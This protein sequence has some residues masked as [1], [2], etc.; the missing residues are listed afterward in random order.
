VGRIGGSDRIQTAF[1]VSQLEFPTG[2]APAATAVVLA[3]SDPN[4]FADALVGQPLAVAKGAPILLTPS[5]ALD[6]RDATEIK[7]LIPPGSTVFLLGGT[8]ALTP[9]V[10]N[11]VIALGYNVVRFGG[12]DRFETAAIIADQG[13][14]N[15][16]TVLESDGLNFPDALS[17]GVAASKLKG[18]VL[19]T[20]GT[21]QAAATAS[22]LAAH[23]PATRFAVGGAATAADPSA[24]SVAGP[25]RFATSSA[26]AAMFFPSPGVAGFATGLDY[27][28][29]LA[30]G[31]R[32]GSLGG[33]LLLVN[34]D[35]VPPP[36]ASYLQ[37]N[38]SSF[39]SGPGGELFGGTSAVSDATRVAIG[40][41]M[42]P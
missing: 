6:G 24:T 32:M 19:L 20:S 28:D 25:D 23:N 21:S 36:V 8:V 16:S 2:I 29:A 38:A 1:N 7:R 26:V 39:V 13:L 37:A 31:A 4:Q 35:N 9:D 12:A 40:Q 17:A 15:P 34:P 18:A 42:N 3:R 14:G 11:A 5:T 10:A 41:D 27:P 33:P 22:Y 30:G